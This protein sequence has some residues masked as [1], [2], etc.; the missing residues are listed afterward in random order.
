MLETVYLCPHSKN[1]H[2]ELLTP[3]LMVFGYEALESLSHEDGALKNGIS[4]LISDPKE[5]SHALGH[6][7]A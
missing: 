4:V 1:S 5:F 3:I 7:R 6:V 2:V